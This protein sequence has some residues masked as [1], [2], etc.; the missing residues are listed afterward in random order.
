M[1]CFASQNDFIVLEL[2]FGRSVAS[3][4][5]FGAYVS[6]KFVLGLDFV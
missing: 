1:W 2:A 3:S 4:L 6:V 5:C